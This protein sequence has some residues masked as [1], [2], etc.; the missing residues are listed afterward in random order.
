MSSGVARPS[1][2]RLEINSADT[3]DDETLYQEL[4]NKSIEEHG[5]LAKSVL[6]TL[7]QIHGTTS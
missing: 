3:I 7:S 2:S 6:G 1:L 4:W 5:E